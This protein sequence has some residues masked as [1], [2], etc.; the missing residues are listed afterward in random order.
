MECWCKQESSLGEN[1]PRAEVFPLEKGP[2]TILDGN[3]P[4]RARRS[5]NI[6]GH[7]GNSLVMRPITARSL[8]P[9]SYAVIL[10]RMP[11]DRLSSCEKGLRGSM[12]SE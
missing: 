9:I 12:S 4:W 1:C 10:R 5:M 11:R 3:D 2:L 7:L 8:S 6:K